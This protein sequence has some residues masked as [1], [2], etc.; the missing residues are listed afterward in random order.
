[1]PRAPPNARALCAR[2]GAEGRRRACAACRARR[3]TPERYARGPGSEAVAAPP[4][5]RADRQRPFVR[6]LHRV[7]LDPPASRP[8]LATPMG[9]LGREMRRPPRGAPGDAVVAAHR[10]ALRRRGE[11]HAGR[12]RHSRAVHRVA[13]GPPASRP[14]LATPIEVLGRE[15]RRP[16]RGGAGRC[17]CRRASA[18]LAKAGRAA[19]LQLRWVKTHPMEPRGFPRTRP[20]TRGTRRSLSPA[21]GGRCRPQG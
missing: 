1:M 18:C 21:R 9:V 11:S 8:G 13:L 20:A 16:P 7:G 4:Q 2:A 6:E 12:S 10:H 3:R 15:L 19:C 17:G 5:P 14:G